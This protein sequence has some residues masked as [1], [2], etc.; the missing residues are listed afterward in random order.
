M[1]IFSDFSVEVLSSLLSMGTSNHNCISS[2]HDPV[3]VTAIDRSL[4]LCWLPR[5]LK[6][7]LLST[8]L[9]NN[10]F[11]VITGKEAQ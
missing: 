6:C 3:T 5:D 9:Q 4:L 1:L 11:Y 2:N 7:I 10:S 8:V